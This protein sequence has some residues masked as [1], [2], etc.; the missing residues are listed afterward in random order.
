ML[1]WAKAI[2]L[3][4]LAPLAGACV[5]DLAICCAYYCA[6]VFPRW[7]WVAF[8]VVFVPYFLSHLPRVASGT[9]AFVE[10][11]THE[12]CHLVMG[13][14]TLSWAD[15][16]HAE[17]S[18]GGY[19]HRTETPVSFLST[20]APYYF[21]VATIPFVVARLFVR[22]SIVDALVGATLAFHLVLFLFDFI[23]SRIQ[24]VGQIDGQTVESD[25]RQV[26]GLFSLL[27][28][29]A[30]NALIIA[31]ILNIVYGNRPA[32]IWRC[33]VTGVSRSWEWYN[34][35]FVYLGEL[36]NRFFVVDPWFAARLTLLAWY[37]G[38]Q[39]AGSLLGADPLSQCDRWV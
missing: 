24:Q 1:K 14:L 4:P 21:P 30:A 36:I 26:G 25:T 11:F 27:F 15:V 5:Y 32:V 31:L 18:R 13:F 34:A 22:S 37:V 28:C 19:V 20:L 16:F 3:L 35:I 7:F 23:W 39:P 2:V 6:G 8:G 10:I 29:L 9:R 17:R 33:L 38:P 12:L